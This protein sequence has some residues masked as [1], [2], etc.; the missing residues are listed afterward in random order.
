MNHLLVNT[1]DNVYFINSTNYTDVC[2][3]ISSYNIVTTSDNTYTIDPAST[4]TNYSLVIINDDI[5]SIIN[6]TIL[7]HTNNA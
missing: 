2:K 4:F 1:N 6:T 5:Y 3:N 7:V